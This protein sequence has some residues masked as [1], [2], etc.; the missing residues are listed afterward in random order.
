MNF[1]LLIQC[2]YDRRSLHLSALE[3]ARAVLRNGHNI[4][5]VF[6]YGEGIWIAN[7]SVVPPQDETDLLQEWQ[8]LIAEHELDAVV[9]IAAALKRGILDQAESKRY[10]KEAAVLSPGFQLSGLGQLVEA[11]ASSD[12]VI[13]FT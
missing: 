2:S 6:F 11:M 13:T 7:G 10:D 9:C 4:Q 1:T 12:R 8:A 5:R 3:F